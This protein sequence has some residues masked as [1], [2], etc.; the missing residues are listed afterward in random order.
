MIK[1]SDQLKGMGIGSLFLSLFGGV[2]MLV[3]LDAQTLLW[4]ATCVLLPTSLLALRAIGV[5]LSSR[6]VRAREPEATP[7]DRARARIIGR[8]FSWI[9]LIE[10]GVIAAVANWLSSTGRQDWIVPAVGIVVGLHF[11]PL[12]RLFRYTLYYWTGGFEVAACVVIGWSLRAH[13]QAA[14]PLVGLA[15]G[16]SLWVTVLVVLV[17]A[18][19]LRARA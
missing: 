4:V 14:D 16:L 12:A 19:W 15:M 13:L 11:L 10:F 8:Q 2:W 9:F 18:R 17:Q 5:I 1:V 7:E 3:A 6:E